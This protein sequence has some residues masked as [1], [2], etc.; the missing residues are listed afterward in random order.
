MDLKKQMSIRNIYASL[1][2]Y[3]AL[4]LLS[5]LEL[6]IIV[7]WSVHT[8]SGA[9]C[10][11]TPSYYEGYDVLMSGRLHAYRTPL[12]PLIIG[13][14]RDLCGQKFSIVA[15]YIF[16]S[17]LFLFSIKWMGRMLTNIT[18]NDRISYWFTAVYALYPGVLSF[19]G[20]I[21]TESMAVSLVTAA[22]YLVSEAYC[23]G[24][25]TKAA[26]SGFVGLSLWLLRPSMMCVVALIFIFWVV[27]FYDWRRRKN[28]VL[29]GVS[30]SFISIVLL[31]VYSAAFQNEYKMAGVSA[32]ATWNNYMTIRGSDAI[33]TGKIESPE[34]KIAVDSFIRTNG[35]ASEINYGWWKEVFYLE[36]EFGI[37]NVNTFVNEQIK[38]N[39][40]KVASYLY[41]D[42]MEDLLSSDCVFTGRDLPLHL[43]SVTRLIRVNN[44]AA[45]LLFLVGLGVL[46]HTDFKMRRIHLF[47]W[48]LFLL[49]AADYLT[50]WAGAPDDFSRLLAQ[51]YPVLIAISCWLL[52]RV[53]KLSRY[54]IASL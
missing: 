23:H 45:F 42:R 19:S 25:G 24:S 18:R 13:L 30:A 21:M 5:A 27:L 1:G 22:L 41:R 29:P 9:M 36:K 52:S 12:Y 53:A 44:G 49:F 16:Q 3:R 50:V 15:V 46:V 6:C 39:P 4:Y 11:D 28:I 31:A 48:L 17:L 2:R 8:G 32:V 37:C 20:M 10:T 7:A 26:L 14:T 38:N 34:M 47:V 43:S 40:R 51:N 33:D 35:K 54:R